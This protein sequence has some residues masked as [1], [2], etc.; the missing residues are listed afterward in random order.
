MIPRQLLPLATAVAL[1]VP[2]AAFAAQ[3]EANDPPKRDGPLSTSP[4]LRSCKKRTER[5]KGGSAIAYFKVCT[6][7]YEFD[8]DQETDSN[9]NYGAF[10]VQANVDA[11]NGWCARSAKV[12]LSY[13]RGVRNKAPK[14]GST[15]R[16]KQRERFTTKLIVDTDGHSAAEASLKN[17]FTLLPGKLRSKMVGNGKTY[18]LRWEGRSKNK[19]ALA[20]GLELAW[21]EDGEAPQIS[22]SVGAVLDHGSC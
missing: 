16:A 4:S 2:A 8:R 22:P 20:A 11:T 17:S 21:P 9:T 10:W 15:E 19:T 6:R 13:S 7:Y 1:L 12:E 5:T 18:R 3:L 14:P